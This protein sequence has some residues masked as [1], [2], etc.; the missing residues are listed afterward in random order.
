[1]LNATDVIYRLFIG[2]ALG[3]VV[4]TY[5]NAGLT[6][7]VIILLV[8]ILIGL[9]FKFLDSYKITFINL[10]V[11]SMA[12]SLGI[13]V[14]FIS[15]QKEFIIKENF[16]D[17]L[18][19]EIVVRMK[20]VD[21]P[22]I[23]QKYQ[24]LTLQY[25][26]KSTCTRLRAK[27]YNFTNIS[28]GDLIEV[29]G[30]IEEVKNFDERFDY[31]G[32][33]QSKGIY[34]NF[35]IKEL[36]K[37]ASGFG[38]KHILFSIKSHFSKNISEFL[39]KEEAALALGL[40]LGMKQGLSKEYKEFFQKTGLMHI[41]VLSGFNITVLFLFINKILFWTRKNIRVLSSIIFIILFVLMVGA[42]APTLRAGIMGVLSALALLFNRDKGNV[43]HMLILAGIFMLLVSPKSI[44][45]DPGFQ[46]SFA[47]ALGIINHANDF[48]RIFDRLR[49]KF[50][51]EIISSSIIAFIFASPFILYYMGS[52]SFISIIANTVVL[53]VV[54]V[55]MFFVLGL[56]ILSITSLQ[57]ILGYISHLLLK[58]ILVFTE[59][60]ANIRFIE[61]NFYLS[62]TF[63]AIFCVIYILADIYK[64]KLY[65]FLNNFPVQIIKE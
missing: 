63:L 52:V 48:L 39:P 12:F 59:I 58:Y 7:S 5:T 25:C 49:I 57:M 21:E 32:Y 51:A 13:F 26:Y 1:M 56:G 62:G 24:F 28:Y 30:V 65:S 34:Y 11:L 10:T 55:T 27:D 3:I 50:V 53:P 4:G 36:R 16:D 23:R 20:V 33:L 61:I 41:V 54:P 40:T 6:V 47:V 22:D 8:S 38:L 19:K 9:C 45:Y 18:N 60:L 37:L 64:E 29:G 31:K 35:K 46:M 44:L 42:D 15:S 2:I 14:N 17:L 43:K